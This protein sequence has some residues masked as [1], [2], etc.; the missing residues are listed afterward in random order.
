MLESPN[1]SSA[2]LLGVLTMLADVTI[3]TFIFK[4]FLIKVLHVEYI[5][6]Y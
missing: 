4:N 6:I 2:C 3:Y 5:K 1:I